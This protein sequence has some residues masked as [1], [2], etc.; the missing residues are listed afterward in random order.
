[1]RAGLFIA[2]ELR[3][4]NDNE[5]VA[6]AAVLRHTEGGVQVRFVRSAQEND[7]RDMEQPFPTGEWVRL[8]IE[9]TGEASESAVT[10]SMDGIPLVE[11]EPMASLGRAS[12]PLLVGLFAEGDIGRQVLMKMEN[13]A[14]VHRGAE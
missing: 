8:R 7:V 13:C 5:I 10:V 1:M 4:R 3:R 6:E 2:R 11:N 14:V 12:T 9:R